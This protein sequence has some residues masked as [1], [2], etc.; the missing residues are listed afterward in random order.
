MEALLQIVYKQCSQQGIHGHLLSTIY[1]RPFDTIAGGKAIELRIPDTVIYRK[2]LLWVRTYRV[3]ATLVIRGLR[4]G[5]KTDDDG[6]NVV[7][8]YFL[9]LDSAVAV[10]EKNLSDLETD[11]D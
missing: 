8:E 10:G 9:A 7:E 3:V 1:H 2:L 5:L 4:T 6:M 11:D